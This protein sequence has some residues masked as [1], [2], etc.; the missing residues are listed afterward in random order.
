[1][2]RRSTVFASLAV[3]AIAAFVA[4]GIWGPDRSWDRG[5]RQVE[6]VRVVDDQ[7]NTIEG[8]NTIIIDSGRHGPPFGFLFFPLGIL[9]VVGFVAFLRGGP[10]RGGPCGPVGYGRA[11][12]LDEWHRRQHASESDTTP[13]GTSAAG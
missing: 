12:W 5:D 1:M 10:R 13:P 7:G 8:A 6:V 11:E 9:L 4:V 3:L 2:S